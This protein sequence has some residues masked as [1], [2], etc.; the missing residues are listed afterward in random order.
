MKKFGTWEWEDGNGFAGKAWTSGSGL[1]VKVCAVVEV[2]VEGRDAVDAAALEERVLGPGVGV[3]EVVLEGRAVSE[4]RCPFIGIVVL[5]ILRDGALILVVVGLGI[6]VISISESESEDI[7]IVS[8]SGSGSGTGVGAIEGVLLGGGFVGD[9][10]RRGPV[11]DVG[12]VDGPSTSITSSSESSIGGL[13][14]LVRVFAVLALDLPCGEDI[15]DVSYMAWPEYQLESMC[16]CGW[17]P[18]L[19]LEA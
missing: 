1:E 15:V 14:A 4:G 8:R 9:F 7:V 19:D 12:V 3:M 18:H 13:G 5:L 2:D 10:V 11:D 16:R 6:E 17:A